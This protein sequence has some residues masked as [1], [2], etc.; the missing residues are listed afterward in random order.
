MSRYLAWI[1]AIS[2]S[3]LCLGACARTVVRPET[4][5]RDFGL[6]RPEQILVYD[7]AV[8]EAEVTEEP[9]KRMLH[10]K[11]ATSE[12]ERQREIGQQVAKALAEELIRDYGVSILTLNGGHAA[13]RSGNANS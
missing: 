12:E 9:I 8:T 5:M 6:P 13:H 7:F 11:S 3:T 10:E 4:R 1:L 2:L